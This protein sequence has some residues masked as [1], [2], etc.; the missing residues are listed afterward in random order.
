MLPN[1][2][3]HKPSVAKDHVKVN[4]E[5]SMSEALV[6]FN[7]GQPD[8]AEAILTRIRGIA[9]HQASPL[10]ALGTIA[11]NTNRPAF[12]IE[13]FKSA[14]KLEPRND[15]VQGWLGL[16]LVREGHHQESIPH[17]QQCLSSQP[18]NEFALVA[19]GQ[20]YAKIGEP[21]K[22]LECFNRALKLNP[23]EPELLFARVGC[24]RNLSRDGEAESDLRKALKKTPRADWYVALA[25]I[26]LLFGRAS[27]AMSSANAAIEIVS[28]NPEADQVAAESTIT[29]AFYLKVHVPSIVGA[30]LVTAEAL[31]ALGRVGEAEIAWTMAKKHAEKG[32]LVLIAKGNVLFSLGRFDEARQA[33][34]EAISLNPVCGQPYYAIVSSK[35]VTED[36]RPF[37][38]SMEQLLLD[39]MLNEPDRSQLLYALGKAYH[40]LQDFEAAMG[41]YDRANAVKKAFAIKSDI[42]ERQTIRQYVDAKIDQFPA[43]FIEKQV[44]AGNPAQLPIFIVGMMRSGTTLLEQILASHRRVGGAGEQT[45]WTGNESKFTS[46]G[47]EKFDYRRLETLSVEYLRILRAAAPGAERVIDKNPANIMLAGILAIAFPNGKIIHIRRHPVD[48]ALSIWMTPMQTNAQFICDRANIVRAYEQYQRIVDHWRRVIPPARYLEVEYEV[49][50]QNPEPTIRRILEF[51]ELEWDPSCLRPDLNDRP[52]RTPSIWQ[53]RQPIYRTSAD[54]WKSYRPWLREFE[55]LFPN[56]N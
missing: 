7:S 10:V 52:V 8:V 11:A 9:P 27:D 5:K 53:V 2:S 13:Y 12:A 51:C 45:F 46:L 49:L 29:G 26:E 31:M 15:Q 1:A 16:L 17:L 40:D 23:E 19:L 20:S 36:D 50:T 56:N 6:A 4:I 44:G 18:R 43:Q 22:A 34:A 42:L 38:K 48:T 3:P 35:K 28:S 39:S 37:L 33:F 54:R 47:P 14:L 30:H 21:D 55:E 25:E 41:F 32:D 24:L